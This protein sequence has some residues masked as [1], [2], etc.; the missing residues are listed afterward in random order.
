MY[1]KPE[2]A[3]GVLFLFYKSLDIQCISEYLTGLNSTEFKGK[4]QERNDDKN[5]TEHNNG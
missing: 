4:F 3:N 5:H 2:V 1:S